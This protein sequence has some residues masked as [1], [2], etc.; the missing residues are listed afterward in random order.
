MLQT[1]APTAP[2]VF[3][4]KMISILTK[5]DISVNM[6]YR[7]FTKKEPTISPV[8]VFSMPHTAPTYNSQSKECEKVQESTTW[9]ADV[10][11]ISNRIAS[12]MKEIEATFKSHSVQQQPS[13]HARILS[14]ATQT[15]EQVIMSDLKASMAIV[16][17]VTKNMVD[18]LRKAEFEVEKDLKAHQDKQTGKR[19]LLQWWKSNAEN[20]KFGT[21]S[22]SNYITPKFTPAPLGSSNMSEDQKNTVKQMLLQKQ[23]EKEA[24]QAQREALRDQI[25]S[26]SGKQSTVKKEVE[27]KEDKKETDSTPVQQQAPA[28]PAQPKE[29]AVPCRPKLSSQQKDILKGT[30]ALLNMVDAL[31]IETK[32]VEE[33]ALEK[34]AL[35]GSH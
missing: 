28:S 29:E 3:E 30:E 25:F 19:R 33:L 5:M 32:R 22:A 14:T 12:H 31:Y 7:T 35:D 6:L 17:H 23:I 9:T 11:K 13:Q 4:E 20:P 34:R 8:N 21:A 10:V 15:P 2:S 18:V 27:K 1:A 26:Q 16:K 24:L